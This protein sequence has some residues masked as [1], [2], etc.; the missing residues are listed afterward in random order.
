MTTS[1]L[2]NSPNSR[3]H[4]N[5]PSLLRGRSVR[6]SGSSSNTWLIAE[7]AP[8]ARAKDHARCELLTP[9]AGGG[10]EPAGSWPRQK[11]R[12]LT[13]QA[14]PR[15]DRRSG[16]RMFSWQTGLITRGEPYGDCRPSLAPNGEMAEGPSSLLAIIFGGDAAQAFPDSIDL[17]LAEEPLEGKLNQGLPGVPRDGSE[18][19]HSREVVFMPVA[20]LIQGVVIESPSG[21]GVAILIVFSGQQAASQRIVRHHSHLETPAERKVF[22][23][24]ARERADYTWVARCEA[25]DNL[26]FRKCRKFPPPAMPHNLRRQDNAPSRS[27]PARPSPR[28]FLQWARHSRADEDNKGP[29][30]PFP[31]AE[32]WRRW[33]YES[34]PLKG[35]FRPARRPSCRELSWPAQPSRACPQAPGRGCFQPSPCYRHWQYRKN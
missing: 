5:F 35:R 13:P 34:Q 4:N 2:S 29:H 21:F 14:A 9:R 16:Y 24:D 19:I 12:R 33:L 1:W 10:P 8:R 6:V 22:L 28:V 20:A 27:A 31:A 7:Q 25:V 30:S 26:F 32:G 3:R 11:F 23:L 17:R 15:F 18:F